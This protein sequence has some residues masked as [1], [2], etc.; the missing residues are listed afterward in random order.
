MD[1]RLIN[2]FV[3][4]CRYVL[5]TMAKLK[6]DVGKPVLQNR[7]P[8]GFAVA[9][10]IDIAGSV[11]G[12]LV[13]GFP[14]EIAAMLTAGL[15][16]EPVRAFDSSCLDAMGEVANMIAGAAKKD[17]PGGLCTMSTPRIYLDRRTLPPAVGPVIVIPC[18]TA[19]GRFDIEVSLRKGRAAGGQAA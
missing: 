15:L 3:T 14:P 19:E 18:L 5:T 10:T 17:L 6:V 4:S 7:K 12:T 16:G 2:P 13:F 9:A 8:A 11:E 1:V